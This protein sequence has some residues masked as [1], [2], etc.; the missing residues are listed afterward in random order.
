MSRGKKQRGAQRR[1]KRQHERRLQENEKARQ[2]NKRR[3]KTSTKVY[4]SFKKLWSYI[5][6]L[7][8]SVPILYRFFQFVISLFKDP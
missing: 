2:Q 4:F 8:V 7:V 6:K 1:S 3:N 5:W